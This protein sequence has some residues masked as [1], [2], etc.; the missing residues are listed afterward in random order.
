MPNAGRT[1]TSGNN[2]WVQNTGTNNQYGFAFTMPENG[3]IQY[4]D[5]YMACSGS[6]MNAVL[7]LWGPS[8]ILL[9]QTAVIS[10]GA[11][12]GGVN[13]QAFQRAALIT[14]YLAAATGLYHVGFWRETGKTAEWSYVSGGGSIYPQA[15]GGGI[16]NVG[17]PGNL[18]GTTTTS[19]QMSAYVEYVKGGLAIASGGSFS[20]YALKRF[21]SGSGTWKRHLLKRWNAGNSTWEWFA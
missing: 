17:S 15:P 2:F 3:L 9:A 18:N 7:C 8:G 11:G 12:A 6:T 1:T 13:G 21:D 10:V 16:A 5:V 19:G 20:K 14:P 4:L